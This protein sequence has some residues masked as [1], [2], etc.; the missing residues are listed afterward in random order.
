M[1]RAVVL[2]LALTSSLTA[3]GSS[4]SGASSA[5]PSA[6]AAA[7]SAT[8]TGSC[9]PSGHGTTDLTK[10]PVVARSTAPA[11]A[12]T[13]TIDI[14]CGTG[15]EAKKGSSVEV[16]YVGLLY[17][18]GSEFD[19]SWGRGANETLPFTVGSGVIPGFSKGTEGMRVGGRR[20]VIIPSKDGYGDTG[21]GP[22]PGGA[23]LVFVID[24]V[25]VG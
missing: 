14:V 21:T 15:A 17:Q 25:K 3:C 16:K 19:S 5:A 8:S 4:S 1:K 24:L 9:T 22:I 11:P 10:K 6:T 13:T 2:A 12:E 7:P 20:E 18:N 23:T